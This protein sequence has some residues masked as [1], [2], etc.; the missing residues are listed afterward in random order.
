MALSIGVER[1]PSSC[2]SLPQ[3]G[4]GGGAGEPAE[5]DGV[6]GASQVEMVRTARMADYVAKYDKLVP[7]GLDP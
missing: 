4:G 1:I 6:K 5:E 7:P 2:E 3:S